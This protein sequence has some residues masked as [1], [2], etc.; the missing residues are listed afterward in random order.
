MTKSPDQLYDAAMALATADYKTPDE[1]GISPAQGVD[2]SLESAGL[3][4]AGSKYPAIG[5][6]SL[7]CCLST[8]VYCPHERLAICSHDNNGQYTQGLERLIGLLA[9]I[10]PQAVEIHAIGSVHDLQEDFNEAKEDLKR[11]LAL[12]ETIPERTGAAYSLKTFDVMHKPHPTAVGIDSRTGR[13]LRASDM[14]TEAQCSPPLRKH[15]HEMELDD[16]SLEGIALFETFRDLGWASRP[17][18]KAINDPYLD[19]DGRKFPAGSP[20]VPW[21]RGKDR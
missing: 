11:Y 10:R 14:L 3:T 12:C 6:S 9:K 8:I 20:D 16:G 13:L 18:D 17:E 7:Q 15:D 5:T 2:I 1:M 21:G 4:Y 19:F